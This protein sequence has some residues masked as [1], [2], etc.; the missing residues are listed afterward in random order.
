MVN[1]NSRGMHPPRVLQMPATTESA[2]SAKALLTMSITLNPIRLDDGVYRTLFIPSPTIIIGEAGFEITVS[3]RAGL[4]KIRHDAF[5][6]RE[7][8]SWV[9]H[10]TVVV[11]QDKPGDE[12]VSR[13]R[14]RLEL[15]SS[16]VS[17][18]QEQLNRDFLENV[19]AA[20]T[21]LVPLSPKDLHP[22][23]QRPPP[24]VPPTYHHYSPRASV[25]E[26]TAAPTIKRATVL[27]PRAL[28]RC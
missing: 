26:G 18:G 9:T 16:W 2:T 3:E 13:W 24:L 1:F 12:E 17:L 23:R 10:P 6:S 28:T 5:C 4:H 7:E 25:M 14:P 22:S 27:L 19:K 21:P 11:K 15:E 20:A 8:N